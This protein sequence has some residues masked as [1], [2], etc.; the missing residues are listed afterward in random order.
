MVTCGTDKK[1]WWKQYDKNP[2][3][4]EIMIL[5]WKASIVNRVKGAQNPIKIGRLLLKGYNDLASLRPDLALEWD[6]KQN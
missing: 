3:T 4:G 2:T 5:E 6:Y 1:V